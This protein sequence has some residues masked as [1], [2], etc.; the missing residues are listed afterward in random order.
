MNLQTKRCYLW[1]FLLLYT[2]SNAKYTIVVQFVLVHVY[3]RSD[4]FINK[5]FHFLNKNTRKWPKPIDDVIPLNY[6]VVSTTLNVSVAQ[7]EGTREFK[8][9][10]L[11]LLCGPR[12]RAAINL[13]ACFIKSFPWI[14][15]LHSLSEGYP[16]QLLY[17]S[18]PV[19]F[20]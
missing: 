19:L 4:C 10:S 13:M 18:F 17:F 16:Q 1:A 2:Y 3:I 12:C 6:K 20:I 14:F 7:H 5:E 11:L 9:W 15:N 8:Y